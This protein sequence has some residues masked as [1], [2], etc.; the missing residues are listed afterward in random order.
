[1]LVAFGDLDTFLVSGRSVIA[2]PTLA[3][4]KEAV[5]QLTMAQIDP[6]TGAAQLRALTNRVARVVR[7]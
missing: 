4:A 7:R 3:A 6:P 1:M 2:S 5:F